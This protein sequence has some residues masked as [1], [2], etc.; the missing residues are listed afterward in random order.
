MKILYPYPEPLPSGNARAIQTVATCHALARLHKVFL[1]ADFQSDPLPSLGL[2]TTSSLD[3]VAVRRTLG[4]LTL[5]TWFYR[6][7][8]KLVESTKPDVIY[9]RHPKVAAR[10]VSDGYRAVYEVHEILADKHPD[11]PELARLELNLAQGC[12]GLVFISQGLERRWKELYGHRLPTSI[13]RSGA[14]YDPELKKDLSAGRPEAVYYTGSAYYRWK[15]LETLLS[16]MERLPAVE[17]VLVGDLNASIASC[18]GRITCLGRLSHKQ[19]ED[20]LRKA[21]ITVIPN[22]A[23]DLVSRLY[24]SPLKLV[25]YMAAKTAIVASDLPSVRE[26]VSEKEAIF[27]KPDDP[28]SLA[29]GIRVLLEDGLLRE[30]LASAAHRKA[31]GFSWNERARRLSNFFLELR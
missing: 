11:N 24:T 28:E 16:A 26:L 8:R 22:S 4:P 20:V 13:V 31:D 23:R 5:G 10:L 14:F 27:F 15:G 30:R 7:L 12:A 2:G 1:V 18:S 6:R 19:V 25:E 21:A 17:L 9:V 3:L 29:E